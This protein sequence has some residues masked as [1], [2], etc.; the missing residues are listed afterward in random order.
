MNRW[1]VVC[2]VFPACDVGPDMHLHEC[3]RAV[4]FALTCVQERSSGQEWLQQDVQL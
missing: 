3:A 1:C 2:P 4:K